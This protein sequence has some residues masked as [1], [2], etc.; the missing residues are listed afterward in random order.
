MALSLELDSSHH[1]EEESLTS[2]WAGAGEKLA[3]VN[4]TLKS[5][6]SGKEM[7][8]SI[9][10]LFGGLAVGLSTPTGTALVGKG[11]KLEL[12]GM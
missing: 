8:S 4:T 9:S 2:C 6:L 11:Q 7:A 5:E 1:M 10:P 12:C 3:G